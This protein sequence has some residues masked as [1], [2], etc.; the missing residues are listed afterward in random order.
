MT[1]FVYSGPRK[2]PLDQVSLNGAKTAAA[3]QALGVG[4]GDSFATFMRNDIAMLETKIAG[5]LTG[6]YAVPVNWHAT[7]EEASYMFTDSGAKV[8]IAHADLLPGVASHLPA[9]VPVIVCATPPEI[10]GAYG[11]PSELCAVPGGMTDYETWRDG[12][13]PLTGEPPPQRG[14]MIY[15]SGTTGNPKGVRRE[16]TSA[17]RQ[18]RIAEMALRSFGIRSGGTVAMT[19]PMYH[20]APGAYAS[21]AMALGND[22][23]LLPRFDPEDLLRAIDEH[24]ISHMHVVPTMFMRM[25]RLPDEVKAKYDLSSLV[26]VIHG[27]APCP[28][29]AKKRMIEWWGDVI[30]EYYGSTEAGVVT[31][32]NS[33]DWMTKPGTVGRPLDGTTVKI[34]D[35]DANLLPVGASGEIY[36]NLNDLSDFTYH[37]KEDKRA[38]I[39]RNGMVTNGDVGYIDEDGYVFLNDRKRDMIISG[40][41]N[42]YPAEIEAALQDMPGVQDCAVFGIPHEDFGE[43]V[44][45]AVET[46]P[47][48]SLTG[49]AVR[50]YLKAHISSYKVPREV[51]FH[52]AMPREDTGKIFKR[53]LRQPYWDKAGR[54]I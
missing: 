16:P 31:V 37:N 26:H 27:A 1:Y 41:V 5:N 32:V 25:L 18:A 23:H 39:E 28:P 44:A 9:G 7:A 36:M 35:D 22:I 53:K 49:D 2:V 46:L 19:G 40:G 33:V 10:A 13:Q 14:S 34:Y 30:Y 54:Q 17:E 24:K 11:V 48:V 51:T 12:C 38:E 52:D 42:I 20:S 15:T 4:D 47:G 50:D 29:E 8:I 43:S 6:A 45:A 3:L 21:I